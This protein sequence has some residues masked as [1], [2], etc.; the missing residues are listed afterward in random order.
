M[1][2]GK[3]MAFSN[4]AHVAVVPESNTLY[5]ILCNSSHVANITPE[6]EV[7]VLEGCEDFEQEILQ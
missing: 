1:N 7:T 5:N 3:I 4:S 2:K 6:G